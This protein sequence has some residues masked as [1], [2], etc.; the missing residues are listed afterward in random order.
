VSSERILVVDDE[1]A[2]VGLI[3]DALDRE[4]YIVQGEI[5]SRKAARVFETFK[6]GACILD[7]NMPHLAGS[8][9]LEIF[10]GLD[11]TVAILFVTGQ[12]EAALVVDLMKRGSID[13]LLKP[14]KLTMLTEAVRRAL[15]HRRSA[16]ENEEYRLNL[17]RIV[18]EK[19]K[20]LD[21]ALRSLTNVHASTLD[22]LSQ[23]LD[24][25][26]QSTSGHSRRVAGLTA[27]VARHLGLNGDELVQIEHGALLHDLGK[28]K[29]PDRILWKP[30]KL[31]DDEWVTI[32]QHP[33]HGYDFLRN[34]GFLQGAAEVVLAH[35]E[36]FDGSGYPRGLSREEIPIGARIFAIVDAVDAMIYKRPYNH[37]PVTYRAAA[38]EVRR[39]AGQH[40][41]PTLIPKALEVL[42]DRIPQ[43]LLG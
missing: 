41:D 38:E 32:R 21:E 18:H 19:T 17:E 20:A 29:V 8:A 2:V 36:R 7:L 35:H 24:F 28:L 9:L 10:K 5:D 26:D 16:I 13:V 15:D 39:C 40:F 37:A 22:A 43:Q 11:P 1:P 14:V 30:S 25:R 42:E 3:I 33:Q 31:T 34:I 4:G 27:N 12:N 23:A 6:P